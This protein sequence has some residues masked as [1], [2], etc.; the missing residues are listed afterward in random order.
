MGFQ[1]CY[2]HTDIHVIEG[3]AVCMFAQISGMHVGAR[4]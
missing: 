3:S 2:I 1:A 4:R